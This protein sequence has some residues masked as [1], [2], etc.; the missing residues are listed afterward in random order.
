MQ[1][2]FDVGTSTTKTPPSINNNQNND[3]TNGDQTSSAVAAIGSASC[4]GGKVKRK[5]LD[6]NLREGMQPLTI[7]E[8]RRNLGKRASIFRNN[9]LN[10]IIIIY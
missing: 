6:D 3:N 4:N 5:C 2:L 10:E 7:S 1:N 8:S 9:L